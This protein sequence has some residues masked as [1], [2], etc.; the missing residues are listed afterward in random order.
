MKYLLMFPAIFLCTF[1][2]VS[3]QPYILTQYMVMPVSVNPA[4]AGLASDMRVAAV[5]KSQWSNVSPNPAVTGVFSFDMPVL[6][7]VLPH[8]DGVGI[9]FNG[10]HDR[11]VNGQKKRTTGGIAL[12]YHKALGKDRAHRISLGMQ[13]QAYVKVTENVYYLNGSI[14]VRD[15]KSNY[16]DFG[17]GVLHSGAVSRNVVIYSGYSWCRLGGYTFGNSEALVPNNLHSGNAGAAISLSGRTSVFGGVFYRYSAPGKNVGGNAIAS[18]RLS[19]D[20]STKNRGTVLHFGAWYSYQH[21]IS[22]YAGIEYAGLRLGMSYNL[23]VS[24]S[25]ISYSTVGG[26]EVSLLWI[27]NLSRLSSP[28]LF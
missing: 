12:S 3:A 7:G 19:A 2:V 9:G 8:G 15:K 22:P 14:L 27:G 1:S 20:G 25:P 16:G 23:N 4:M 18:F 24:P 6:T 11:V 17:F 10:S 26:Y 13:G 21:A 5:Y 28:R